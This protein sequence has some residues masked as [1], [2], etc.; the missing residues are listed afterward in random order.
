[1][2][3]SGHQMGRH[4][5]KNI[6]IFSDGT[7]QAGGLRPDQRLSNIYK[8]YRAMRS[9]PDS[10][11]DPTDQVAYYDPGLG[12]ES[13]NSHTKIPALRF[14][15]NALDLAFGHG[16]TKNIIECYEFIIKHYEPGDH[17]YLFGFS[18]GGYTARCLASVIYLCGIPQTLPGTKSLPKFGKELRKISKEAVNKVYKHGSGRDRDEYRPER[19]ELAK[20]FRKKY[21]AN[22]ENFEANAAPYFIG[23][24]D[25]VAAL[26][27]K[28]LVS[29]MLFVIG[30]ALFVL[31]YIF[32]NPKLAIIT[33]VA[34]GLAS[35]FYIIRILVMRFK[36]IRDFPSKGDYSFHFTQPKNQYYRQVLDKRVKYARQANAIDE[37]RV[38]FQR[39][40]WKV[41]PENKP[42]PYPETEAEWFQQI[43]F[44]GNHSDIGGSYP[45]DESR[46]SDVSLSWMVEQLKSINEPP[47]FDDTKLKLYPD[48]LGMQHSEVL[49]QLERRPAWVPKFL[50]PRWE[51]KPRKEARGTVTHPS[52]LERF[53]AESVLQFG[54]AA[55]YRPENMREDINFE[56]FYEKE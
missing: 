27:N 52:V 25:T 30:V 47:L 11:I 36:S 31:M 28:A 9:G 41:Y 49:A 24:F 23:T 5:S 33:L 53:E 42:E 12:S 10:I 39:V 38:N 6:L 19:H 48:P 46:L 45:E 56:Q 7:G 26:G 50:W 22:N 37:T 2:L 1:M 14:V 4:M 20:R 35:L 29:L 13:E 54:T 15:K 32:I 17:I 40:K 3:S 16:I 8:L 51:E 43:W 55:S 44:A 18:R 21:G 34:F